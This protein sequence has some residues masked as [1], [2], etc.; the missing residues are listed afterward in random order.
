M[1]VGGKFTSGGVNLACSQQDT[2]NVHQ[3][4]CLQYR[5]PQFHQYLQRQRC[6]WEEEFFF[7]FLTT[8]LAKLF[9]LSKYPLNPISRQGTSTTR[10][11]SRFPKTT[12]VNN[13]IQAPDSHQVT[14]LNLR[15]VSASS[16]SLALWLFPPLQH[17]NS[18][19]LP[20]LP[21]LVSSPP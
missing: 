19:P 10:Q 11:R 13:Q 15:I 3:L 2:P 6:K 20:Y 17:P 1:M 18:P 7:R 21:H 16:C 14:P 12:Q 5:Y 4:I 9:S 8:R